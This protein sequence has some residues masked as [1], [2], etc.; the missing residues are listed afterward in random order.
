MLIDLLNHTPFL[1]DNKVQ[2]K[3][4]HFGWRFLKYDLI[5][6]F[7]ANINRLFPAVFPAFPFI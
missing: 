5:N 4:R 2:T 1:V 6:S 7:F 3:N